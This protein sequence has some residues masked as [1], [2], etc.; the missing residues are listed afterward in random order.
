PRSATRSVRSCAAR[1][2]AD[3]PRDPPDAECGSSELLQ[4]RQHLL[5]LQSIRGAVHHQPGGDL[6][7]LVDYH[8]TVLF[9][10]ATGPRQIAA[11][12]REPLERGPLQTAL[13]QGDGQHASGTSASRSSENPTAG[14]GSPKRP[15]RVSYRP[16]PPTGRG[17]PVA[18]RLK[19]MPV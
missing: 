11:R 19:T 4:E 7:D 13:R 10:R 2:P 15:S 8:Q 5:H 9:P 3:D 18:Y 6:Q 12:V 14:R 1:S 16:P 17:A